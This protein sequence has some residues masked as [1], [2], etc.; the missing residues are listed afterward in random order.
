[1]AVITSPDTIVSVTVT[2]GNQE[3]DGVYPITITQITPTGQPVAIEYNGTRI[4][5]GPAAAGTGT[6]G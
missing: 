6:E 3:V 1:M 4:F 2:V 5:E